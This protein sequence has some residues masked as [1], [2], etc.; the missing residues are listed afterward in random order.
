M[1]TTAWS[2]AFDSYIVRQGLSSAEVAVALKKAP[3]NVSYW[4]R[5]AVPRAKMRRVIERWSKGK[6]RA[7]LGDR[8]SQAAAA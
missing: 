2:A 8:R 4:R 6:V 7:S 3:S 1:T 5:G